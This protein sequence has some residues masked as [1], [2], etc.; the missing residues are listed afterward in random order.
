MHAATFYNGW[1]SIQKSRSTV[2]SSAAAN[3]IASVAEGVNTQFSTVFTVFRVTATFS[4]KS[5]CV[6]PN[7]FRLSLM[8]FRSES[9]NVIGAAFEH[10]ETN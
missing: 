8:R 5:A 1:G 6:R 9:A 7:S 10:A 2:W 4:A 3:L